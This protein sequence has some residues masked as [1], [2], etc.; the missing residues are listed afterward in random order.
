MEKYVRHRKPEEKDVAYKHHEL[1]LRSDNEGTVA[2]GRLEYFGDPFPFFYVSGVASF[3]ERK[4]N[5]GELVRKMNAFLSD[6]KKAG[7]LMSQVGTLYAREGWKPVSGHPDWWAYNLPPT[8]TEEM[9]DRAIRRIDAH[10][11]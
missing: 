10:D 11:S 9:I 5:G 3:H 7:F 8:A 2:L 4:G 6:R 1:Q